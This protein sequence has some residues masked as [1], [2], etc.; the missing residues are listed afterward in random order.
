[1]HEREEEADPADIQTFARKQL[2]DVVA[3][4]NDNRDALELDPDM[5]LL[6]FQGS[7]RKNSAEGDRDNGLDVVGGI[8]GLQFDSM[9]LQDTHQRVVNDLEGSQSFYL[10]NPYSSIKDSEA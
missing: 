8:S 3:F 1:M 10:R 7:S 5:D 4:E 2:E 6:S 9:P